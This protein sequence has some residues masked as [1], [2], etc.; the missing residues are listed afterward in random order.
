MD[1]GVDDLPAGTGTGSGLLGM[2]ER[3]ALH[4]GAFVA[5]PAAGGG[6]RLRAVLPLTGVRREA[7][8]DD[9]AVDPQPVS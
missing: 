4:G 8:S 5:G 9:P 3:V 7:P 2:R 6:V 1:E